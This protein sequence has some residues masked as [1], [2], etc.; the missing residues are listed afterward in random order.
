LHG[1][2]GVIDEQDRRLGAV[3]AERNNLAAEAVAL[4]GQLEATEADRSERLGMI[5]E[6]G[7]RLGEVEKERYDL[8]AELLAMRERL[9][10]AEADQAASLEVI[11][12]RELQVEQLAVERRDLQSEIQVQRDQLGILIAQ[13]RVLQQSFQVLQNTRVCRLLRKLGRW[14]F[15]EHMTDEPSRRSWTSTLQPR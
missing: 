10:R 13:L 3:E 2:L 14:K 7:R 15:V 4:R 1:R 6:Q 11:Q 9:E 12:E 5:E 8:A